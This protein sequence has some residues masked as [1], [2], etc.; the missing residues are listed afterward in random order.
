MEGLNK[1]RLRGRNFALTILL[2]IFIAIMVGVLFNLIV[3]YVYEP[4]EYDKVCRGAGAT[5]PYPVKYGV[6][7]EQCG[8]C[9]FSKTLQE[10]TDACAQESGFPVY[11]YDDKGCTISIKECNMCNKEFEDAIAK[12]NKNTFFIFAAIGFI[13][14]IAGLYAAPLLVQIST[15]P[16]GAF[17]VIEAA[18]KNFDDKLLI[19]ITFALLIVAAV[20]LALR[21][22][23]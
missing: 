22:L 9:T 6:G 7:N 16:T 23:K 20:V 12:Y 10:E 11:D 1:E 17:L 4:P 5:G 14:I 2:G 21:K 15:L 19:I 18:A 8:N 3:S 13:L